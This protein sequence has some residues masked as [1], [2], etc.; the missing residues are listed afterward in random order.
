VKSA[1][2]NIDKERI[3]ER[4][5]NTTH[6]GNGIGKRLGILQKFL[7]GGLEEGEITLIVV[8]FLVR[9]LWSGSG[10]N[11]QRSVQRKHGA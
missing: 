2:E 3:R 8:K 9:R 4:Q 5:D 11:R 1:G 7:R 10:R 6:A